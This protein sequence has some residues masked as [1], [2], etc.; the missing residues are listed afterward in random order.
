MKPIKAYG[1]FDDNNELMSVHGFIHAIIPYKK[2]AREACEDIEKEK[3]FKCTFK[4]LL[5]TEV[6]Q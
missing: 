6:E 3:G 4:K 5:I 2:Y 1:I